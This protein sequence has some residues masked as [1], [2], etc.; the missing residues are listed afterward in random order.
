MESKLDD[1]N[2]EFSDS[3]SHIYECPEDLLSNMLS[4]SS[5]VTKGE[6][7]YNEV[8]NDYSE[9]GVVDCGAYKKKQA[10][11]SGPASYQTPSTPV[12]KGP[13]LDECKVSSLGHTQ[14]YDVPRGANQSGQ[15]PVNY[16]SLV[17]NVKP[18]KN[19]YE[20][21]AVQKSVGG[22]APSTS[23]GFSDPSA[24]KTSS[25]NGHPSQLGIPNGALNSV[26]LPSTNDDSQDEDEYIAMNSSTYN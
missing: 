22:S 1:V 12:R 5:T 13:H 21:N 10:K 26:G 20:D 24:S 3:G 14:G 4:K 17:S 11:C 18:V 25:Q 8:H 16:I 19:V 23:S 6:I 9:I 7:V 2:F 15:K